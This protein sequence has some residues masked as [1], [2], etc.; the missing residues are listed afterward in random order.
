MCGDMLF[1]GRPGRVFCITESGVKSSNFTVGHGKFLYL[2]L[3]I[4]K[5]V[6]STKMS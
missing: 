2:V 6:E 5:F 4:L 1:S 3:M